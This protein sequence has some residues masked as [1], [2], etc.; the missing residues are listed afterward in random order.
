[1]KRAA[2]I[3]IGYRFSLCHQLQEAIKHMTPLDT[4]D[5]MLE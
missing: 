4:G 1:M 5:F 3:L 2:E